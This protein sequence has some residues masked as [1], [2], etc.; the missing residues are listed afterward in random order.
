VVVHRPSLS[1]VRTGTSNC[2]PNNVTEPAQID[3]YYGHDGFTWA[4]PYSFK[5]SDGS[6]AQRPIGMRGDLALSFPAQTAQYVKLTI[7]RAPYWAFVDE[8]TFPP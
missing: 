2:D 7:T 1:P 5:K 3:V 4:G 8:V 6:L